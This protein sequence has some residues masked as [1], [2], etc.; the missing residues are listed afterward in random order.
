MTNAT[1]TLDP[2]ALARATARAMYDA[3]R[4]SVV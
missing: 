2:D 1:A 4:K 3:D